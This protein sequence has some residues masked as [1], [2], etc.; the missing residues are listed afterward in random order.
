MIR[1][2]VVTGHEFSGV[3]ERVGKDVIG[4]EPGDPVCSEEI[5]WCGACDACRAGRP[6]YCIRLTELGFTFNGAHAEMVL[7]REKY[8]WSIDALIER[9]GPRRGFE[10]GALVEPTSVAYIGM[11]VQSSFRPGANVG[12]IGRG[13]NWTGGGRSGT[14]GGGGEDC[15]DRAI[16]TPTRVGARDGRR[17]GI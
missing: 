12:V 4:L 16:C 3:V 11:F 17:R 15:G 6:N 8:C 14:G 13:S 5:A 10:A 1:T 2:P 9:F 7:T